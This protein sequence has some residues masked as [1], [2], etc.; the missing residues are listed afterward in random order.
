MNDSDRLKAVEDVVAV[1]APAVEALDEQAGKF[2][3]LT[4]D[5]EVDA[6]GRLA[7]KVKTELEA[8]NNERLR[9]TR[10]IDAH[11]AAIIDAV[12]PL[13]SRLEEID[14]HL[15]GAL[16]EQRRAEQARLDGEAAAKEAAFQRALSNG[17]HA[18]AQA[19]IEEQLASPARDKA[20]MPAGT[21]TGGRWYALVVD[22]EA[23][24]AWCAAEKELV[25]LLPNGSALNAIASATKGPSLIPGVSFK[26]KEWVT[27]GAKR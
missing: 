12:R 17:D 14:Q 2:G 18:A 23:F 4:T 21:G 10:P 22:F 25:Y 11:K 20:Y 13:T 3:T 15:K 19:A 7:V 26:K 24:V 9:I 6:A 1:H 16:D 5:E 27:V 8:L